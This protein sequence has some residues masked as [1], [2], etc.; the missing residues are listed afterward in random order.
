MTTFDEREKGFEAKYKHDQELQFKVGAR[1][2]KLLGLWAAELL[3]LSGDD[4]SAYAREVIESDFDEPGDDDVL[5]KV[6]G[7]LSAKGV[8]KSRPQVRK[9][10]DDL[11]EVARRQIMEEVTGG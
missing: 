2:N 4:A 11:M 5:R 6:L 10:M 1:R 3:G 9:Q 8:D 7:D